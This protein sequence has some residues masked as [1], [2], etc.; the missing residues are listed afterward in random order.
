VELLGLCAS[1]AFPEQV[2]KLPGFED[3]LA[4]YAT[5][6]CAVDEARGRELIRLIYA[7]NAAPSKSMPNAICL[8]PRMLAIHFVNDEGTSRHS[9][10]YFPAA[11]E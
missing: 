9:R 8:N 1:V 3:G 10:L 2:R 4:R 7:P 6:P 5:S 11:G